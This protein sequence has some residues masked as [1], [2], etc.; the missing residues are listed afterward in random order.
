MENFEYNSSCN[1]GKVRFKAFGDPILTGVCYCDDCQAGGRLMESLEG[2]PDVLDSD[3]ASS[4]L[5]FRDDRFECISGEEFLE[6]VSHKDRSWTKRY[7]ATCCNSGMYIK[8]EPG[9][10]VSA[11][12]KRFSGDLPPVEMRNQM[13]FRNSD[14][15]LPDKA[16]TYHRFPMS[17]FGRLIKARVAMLFGR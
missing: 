1:C 9:H 7:V 14:L 5:V 16:P 3:G 4:T 12:R 8:F 2:A 13:R 15:P 11:Y 17:L 6:N 10:W